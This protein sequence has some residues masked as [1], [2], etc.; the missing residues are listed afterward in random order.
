MPV[1]GIPVNLLFERIGTKLDRE[2]LVVHLQHLGCDVEGYATVRRFRCTIC[3]NTVEITETENPP[4]VCALCGVDLRERAEALVELGRADVIRMELLAVRPDMFDPGGLARVLRHYLGEETEPARYEVA[5][6]TLR[7]LVDPAVRGEA[8]PRPFIACAAIR[9]FS[10]TDDLLK[11]VM[12]LQE[13]LH[14]AVG[15]DRKHASIGVY[16]LDTVRG[17]ELRYRSVGPEELRFVPLGVDP[18]SPGS[19]QTPREILERHPKGRAYAHLLARFAR[20]PLLED[21]GGRVLSMPPIINSEETRLRSSSRSFF[22]DVTGTGERIVSRAL[23]VLCTSLLELDRRATLEAVEVVYPGGEG[24][25]GT[26]TRTPDLSPQIVQLDARATARLIGVELGVGDVERHL[27]QMGHEVRPGAAEGELVVEVPAYRNDILHEVDLGEDVA[28]AYGYHNIV[29]TLVPTMTVGNELPGERLAQDA[30]RALTG[31]GYFEV[32][33][34][35]LSAPE[36]NYDSLRTPRRED[37]VV[38]ENPISALQTMIRTTLLPGLLDTLSLNTNAELPQRLFEV[39]N[40]TLV[41]AGAETGAREHRRVAAV[42]IGPRVDYAAIRSTAEALLR[43]L[44]YGLEVAP[45]AAPCLLEGRGAAVFAR[46]G[47]V[48]RRVG[49]MGEVH[50]EVLERYRLV[51]PAA[52]FEIEVDDLLAS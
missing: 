25:A 47:E 12:K 23:N 16:D 38:I 42:A 36:A 2:E 4:T 6:P 19:A 7:V 13:N 49:L 33:T 46:R 22:I 26:A 32:T 43:E 28:I 45:E 1:V 39:G 52:L 29:P 44:G 40:V 48:R 3:D 24:G 15:R 10:L 31:L 51:H 11:V 8:C 30:R 35:I 20:Y 41:D 5:P 50:P 17:P 21:A 9:G 34:L 37:H 18:A 27:R 14:W